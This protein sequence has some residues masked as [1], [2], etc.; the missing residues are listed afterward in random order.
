MQK[1]IRI[2]F[3]PVSERVYARRNDTDHEGPMGPLVDVTEDF[4]DVLF[5]F[6]APGSIRAFGSGN[7]ASG[8]YDENLLICTRNDPKSLIKAI[9]AIEGHMRE[10][11]TQKEI[12]IAK[13][14]TGHKKDIN[15]G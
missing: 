8:D 12:E 2:I 13:R 7:P 6:L 11:F 10:N 3:D 15:D 14:G 9:G 4:Y 1:D 5:S